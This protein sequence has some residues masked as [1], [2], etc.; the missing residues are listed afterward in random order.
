MILALAAM[1]W[2][3][4]FTGTVVLSV[5]GYIGFLKLDNAALQVK[6]D[7]Q[8]QEIERLEIRVAGK[9]A[10][11]NELV[12]SIQQQNARID[13]WEN[14]RVAREKAS[15]EALVLIRIESER[16]RKVIADLQAVTPVTCGES[17]ALID[18]VLGL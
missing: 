15:S 14:V 6:L 11:I 17:V 10:E 4:I 2:G 12:A 8:V 3:K 18:E 9:Q 7:G 16:T 13:Q 5:A 1:P